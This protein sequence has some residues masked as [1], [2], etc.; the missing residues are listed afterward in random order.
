MPEEVEAPVIR[1]IYETTAFDAERGTYR[2][3]VIRVEYPPGSFHDITI[4]KDEYDPEKV[5]QYVS[6]WLSQYGKWLGKS[7]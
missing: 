2:A 5:P 4:P 7:V 3:V 1:R 6:E